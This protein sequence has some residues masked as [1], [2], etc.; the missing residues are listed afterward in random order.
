MSENIHFDKLAKYEIVNIVVFGFI[1]ALALFAY[2]VFALLQAK[3]AFVG[4]GHFPTGTLVYFYG[5]QARLISTI[6]IGA[7]IT[8]F[9]LV[10]LKR[11]VRSYK[12]SLY[13]TLL[14]WFGMVLVL[15]GLI[16]L[17]AIMLSVLF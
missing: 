14:T 16:T 12:A 9:S 1:L 13:A 11:I 10:F 6:Y 7:G 4:R 5:A 8:I 2:G 3:C 15:F 17:V